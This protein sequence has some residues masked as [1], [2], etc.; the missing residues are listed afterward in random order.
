MGSRLQTSLPVPVRCENLFLYVV[1]QMDLVCPSFFSHD[2]HPTRIYWS[3]QYF[4]FIW[5]ILTKLSLS[6]RSEWRSPPIYLWEWVCNN[7]VLFIINKV[8]P[9]Y[10]FWFQMSHPRKNI[11]PLDRSQNSS[12]DQWDW[13]EIWK[14][15]PKEEKDK[16]DSRDFSEPR[17]NETSEIFCFEY[18]IRL[19]RR[20][21]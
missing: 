17:E 18:L 11:C 20:A 10:C 21:K 6:Q 13:P 8:L 12:T 16:I 7:F 4:Q 19:L 3:L 1:I 14:T 5:L 15:W 9:K 2:I